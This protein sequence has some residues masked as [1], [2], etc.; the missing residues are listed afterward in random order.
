MVRVPI[1]N[2]EDGLGVTVHQQD[3]DSDAS[4]ENR[5]FSGCIRILAST[6]LNPSNNRVHLEAIKCTSTQPKQVND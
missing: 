5:E 1:E 3:N 4:A 6:D 2:V